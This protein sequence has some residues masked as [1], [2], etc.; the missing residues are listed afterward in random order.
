LI[1]SR[2]ASFVCA[3]ACACASQ[4]ALAQ[5]YQLVGTYPA[6]EGAFDVLPDGRLIAAVGDTIVVQDGL[7]AGTYAP[8]GSV[9]PGLISAD[10]GASFL[11]VNPSGTTLAIGDNDAGSGPQEVLL[12]D[13][14]SLSL[15]GP[16]TPTLVGA[17]NTSGAWADDDTLFVSGAESFPNGVL[18]RI[19]AGTGAATVV[20][21]GVNGA[22][23]G[24]A[25]QGGTLYTANGFGFGTGFDATGAIAGFDLAVLSTATSPV[26]FSSGQLVATALSAASL[27][28]DDLGNIIV[29]GRNGFGEDTVEGGFVGVIPSGAFPGATS[30]D[31]QML[32]PASGAFDFPGAVFNEATREILV[33][34]GGTIF[35]YA[36]PSPGACA[37]LSVGALALVR[38][39]RNR[40]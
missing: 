19:D 16:T 32:V 5:P 23:G 17:A 34:D 7:N 25:F 21:D 37:M 39:S 36:I 14:A 4:T 3:L 10:F 24:V 40:A 8:V 30:A 26:A 20:I 11:S 18:T 38:R 33:A 27:D 2:T 9:T 13:F 35:R 15:S 6:P 1:A 12:L 29:G 22:S 28:F 31:G